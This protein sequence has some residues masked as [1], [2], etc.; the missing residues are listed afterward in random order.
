MVSP[1]QT[2]E[3]RKVMLTA[4]VTLALAGAGL[5]PATSAPQSDA[6]TIHVD[7]D[8]NPNPSFQIISDNEI[9]IDGFTYNSWEEVAQSG[10]FHQHGTRC[11]VNPLDPQLID[12]L[13][14]PAGTPSDCTLGRTR[15]MPEYDP[16]V[17]KYRIP[18][19]VHVI[20][21]TG[22]TGAMS[23]SRVQSQI[24]ILNE[25]FLAIAG[26][27]GAPG[28]DTQI[29]FYLAEFDP[30]GN[31]T[32][33]ITRSTNNTWFNDGGSYWNTL[34]WDTDRYLNIYTNSASGN[35]GYVPSLPQGGIV[36][37]NSDRVVVL[38]STFGAGAPLAPFNLGRTGTHEVGHYLGLAHTFS[39]GCSNS[40]TSGDLIVDTNPE[41]SPTFGC[42]GARNSC[43]QPAPLDNYM[44][45]A[46]DRCMNKFTPEQANRM[47]CT[48]INYR[49]N[50][51]TLAAGPCNDADLVAPFGSLN[52]SDISTFLTLF[53][54]GN[55]SADLNDD[56]SLN[57]LDISE[58]LAIYGAGCP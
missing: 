41:S 52:F 8:V 43:G 58:Y 29:E 35:L 28:T 45:Y 1:L 12:D 32:T 11:G 20:Q 25:D 56:G 2:S 13:S 26:S 40:Y 30:Q 9:I 53:S 37:S 46:D 57:F 33:G 54:D 49:P 27:N 55:L 34:A 15:I 36:G 17:E 7:Q 31:P 47:R 14:D 39:G 18:V 4:F 24:D 21:T 23:D 10:Y 38:H 19:V 22:G 16:S 50:L 3:K 44:D 51:Y 5:A 6:R 48:L 42:P